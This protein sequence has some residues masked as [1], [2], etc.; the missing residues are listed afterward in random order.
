MRE[1]KATLLD[2]DAFRLLAFPFSGPIPS[3]YTPRGVDLDGQWFSERSDLKLEWL[4]ARP[5]DWHHGKDPTGVMGLNVPDGVPV[6]PSQRAELGKA[7]DPEMTDEG[8]WVTV[9]MNAGE[10]RARL[11][12]AL[13]DQGAALFGSS[14]TIA[15][16]IRVNKAS[17]HIDQW[18]YW[19][20]TLST[21]PQ[22]LHSVLRPFKAALEDALASELYTPSDAFWA[23]LTAELK[24]LEPHLRDG[25]AKAGLLDGDGERAV[26]EMVM[27]RLG[28]T[29]DRLT[30]L[31]RAGD[32]S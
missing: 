9:W 5:V 11:V 16:L 7:V 4:K 26:D 12:K 30:T 22:N 2:D 8:V 29:L 19:R 25:G 14:E 32:T 13:A 31:L 20:Q 15:P 28:M 24:D 1:L 18:P 17:G 21:S 3:P 10:R 27:S 6:P 23:D